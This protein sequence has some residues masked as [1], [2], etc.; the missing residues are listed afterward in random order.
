MSTISQAVAP[1]TKWIKAVAVLAVVGAIAWGLW[2]A[3][4]TIDARAY[5]RGSSESEA[6]YKGKLEALKTSYADARTKAEAAA[7]AAEQASA[8]HNAQVMAYYEQELRDAKQATDRTIADERAGNLKLRQQWATCRAAS[9]MPAPGAG[10]S[11]LD[12][13]ADRDEGTAL[14]L[15]RA[16]DPLVRRQDAKIRAL[17]AIVKADRQPPT[18]SR[19]TH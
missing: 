9:S 1:Y 14:D 17:Q 7:R 11:W 6:K 18:V 8:A 16:I 10:G 15:F 3:Y 19:E 12:A 5:A 13:T 2:H 4:D